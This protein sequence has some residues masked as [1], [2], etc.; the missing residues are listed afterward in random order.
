MAIDENA[1]KCDMAETYGIYDWR[2][3]PLRTVAAFSAGL[4]ENSRIKTIIRG[5]KQPTIE[6]LLMEIHDRLA[7]IIWQR[8]GYGE[9][10]KAPSI[11]D[12]LTDDKQEKADPR[13]K[14]YRTGADFDAAWN[15][16]QEG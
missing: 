9:T 1:W 8:G 14:A 3:L 7:E 13:F 16:T 6:Y 4:R 15:S 2:S 11:R 12:L 10:D 5:E